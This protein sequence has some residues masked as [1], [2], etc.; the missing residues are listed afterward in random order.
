M[1]RTHALLCSTAFLFTASVHGAPPEQQPATPAPATAP[2]AAAVQR[3]KGAIDLPNGMKLDFGVTLTPGAE[4]KPA[5][6]TMDIPLQ[7]VKNVAL[8][9]VVMGAEELKFTLAMPGV[10]PAM[11]AVFTAKP[12]ADGATAEGALHQGGANVPIKMTRLAE[13]APADFGPN[14]PQNPKPPF[15]YTQRDVTY[16]NAK[17]G[18]KLAGTLTIPAGKG[19][20]PVAVMITGSGP[21]DRDESLMGHRPFL[22]IADHLS[23]NGIAVLRADDRGVGGS[24]GNVG[25]ATAQDSVGDVLAAIAL[26]KTVPEIDASHIGVIGHSEGGIIG[27]MAA[28]Q[29]PDIAFVVML[30]GTGLKGRDILTMQSEA[31]YLAAGLSKE[32]IKPAIDQHRHLMDALEQNAPRADIEAAIREMAKTQMSLSP[33]AQPLSDA[34]LDAVVKQQFASLDSKWFRS[35]LFYDPRESLRK[36]AVPVL[37]LNG[38]L[39]VQ[40]PPK[41]N[42]PEIDKAL[43]EAG[44]KDVTVRE[45]PGLN[46]LFQTA[47]TGGPDEYATIEE[48]FSP[49]ALAVMTQWIRAHT[50]DAPGAKH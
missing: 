28:A 14:R 39:D 8:T 41:A 18:T 31:I 21:Q 24:T 3:W 1:M 35:F 22:V 27:P 17:D 29:S 47:K 50:L 32:A 34:Q 46:H 11:Q 23:R 13:G 33:G 5:S 44:N 10:P 6:G 37:A 12:S 40:V 2:A 36:V 19:P 25:E 38:G 15:P 4:G 16:T 9:D 43:K 49:E 7:N 20:F 42:L 26:L 48:T 30:A 45:M